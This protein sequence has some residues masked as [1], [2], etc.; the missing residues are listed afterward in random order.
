MADTAQE[1]GIAADCLLSLIE[2]SLGSEDEASIKIVKLVGRNNIVR[3][4]ISGLRFPGKLC[5]ILADQRPR[6]AIKAV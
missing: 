5:Q 6:R 3:A 1:Q 2:Q 4:R